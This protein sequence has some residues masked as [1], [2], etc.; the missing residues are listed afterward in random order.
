VDS[1]VEFGVDFKCE[2]E[3]AITVLV[4]EISGS[5]NAGIAELRAENAVTYVVFVHPSCIFKC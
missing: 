2:D 4:L 1:L 5:L 3:I